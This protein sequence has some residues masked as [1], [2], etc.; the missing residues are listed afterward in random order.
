[1]EGTPNGFRFFKCPR[2]RLLD[3]PGIATACSA[4]GI[5]GEPQI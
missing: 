1:M 4:I 2:V 5:I 3:D